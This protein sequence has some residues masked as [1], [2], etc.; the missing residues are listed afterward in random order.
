MLGGESAPGHGTGWKSVSP[1]VSVVFVSALG[2]PG[3]LV[4]IEGVAVLPLSATGEP[5]AG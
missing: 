3:W 2:D 4:E 5:L 1:T